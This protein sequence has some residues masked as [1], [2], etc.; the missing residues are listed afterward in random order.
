RRR[1]AG[2]GA[3]RL[4]DQ[5]ALGP[6]HDPADIQDPAGRR[7]AAEALEPIEH[8]GL[9]VPALPDRS[10]GVHTSPM[11]APNPPRSANFIEQIPDGDERLRLV[12]AECGFIRYDNPKIVVGSVVCHEDRV[13]LC[14]RRIDPRAG[15]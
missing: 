14:R 6:V 2:I 3:W 10:Q 8:E 9:Y 4:E 12:C 11:T 15:F 13:L 5:A 1:L 7:L